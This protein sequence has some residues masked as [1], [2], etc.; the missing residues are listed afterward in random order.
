MSLRSR[1]LRWSLLVAGIVLLGGLTFAGISVS[2]EGEP[3]AVDFHHGTHK[4]AF[5]EKNKAFE[6]SG[7]HSDGTGDAKESRPGQTDHKSCDSAGCHLAEF[8]GDKAKEAKVCLNCHVRSSFFQDMSALRPYPLETYANREHTTQFSHRAHMDPK[9]KLDGSPLGCKSCHEGR[10]GR[11]KRHDEKVPEKLRNQEGD[12]TNPGHDNCVKCHG[13]K[14]EAEL[15][16]TKCDGCHVPEKR[17]PV[18]DKD[19][20]VR[21]KFSHEKHQAREG[22]VVGKGEDAPLIIECS[23]CHT[24]VAGAETVEAAVGFAEKG[25]GHKVCRTCHGGARYKGRS[26]FAVTYKGTGCGKCH[27]NKVRFDFQ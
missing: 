12:Y 15:K 13:D 20:S 3:E 27:K 21:K 26:I 9:V 2:Q 19:T 17:A 10:G 18:F 16:M 14:G 1:K 5:S 8:Y 23:V 25:L 6:C 4:K 7:C 11:I 24:K 22:D